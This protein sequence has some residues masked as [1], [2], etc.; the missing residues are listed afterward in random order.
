MAALEP[1]LRETF[2]FLCQLN[3]LQA[4]LCT[5]FPPMSVS[6]KHNDMVAVNRK[7]QDL[8]VSFMSTDPE[9]VRFLLANLRC[10][11]ADLEEDS[12][13]V[14]LSSDEFHDSFDVVVRGS[15][16]QRAASYA[17]AQTGRSKLPPTAILEQRLLS[18]IQFI[19]L[20]VRQWVEHYN[21]DEKRSDMDPY[22]L[23]AEYNEHNTLA[24]YMQETSYVAVNAIPPLMDAC[25]PQGIR[26]HALAFRRQ[27]DEKSAALLAQFPIVAF[28]ASVIRCLN[29]V[30]S[31]IFG[32][33]IDPFGGPDFLFDRY[34]RATREATENCFESHPGNW[35]A[36]NK[37]M[38]DVVEA[39]R[40]GPTG[41]Q[42]ES[43]EQDDDDDAA[44]DQR[45]STPGER[46]RHILYPPEVLGLMTA[47]AGDER[48]LR[49]RRVWTAAE[50]KALR[51]GVR[52]FGESNWK[53][54]KI[55]YKK[56]LMHWTPQ[57]IKEKYHAMKRAFQG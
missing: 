6:M 12:P 22:S 16:S 39:Q 43:H 44:V 29:R 36:L 14:R 53:A 45:P 5:I 8:G 46:R 4:A 15:V 21:A 34:C 32:D 28:Q 51:D 23:F 25:S 31:D 11:V 48:H 37:V 33:M 30:E 35:D 20:P 56:E 3:E 38:T 18:S 47:E 19:L 26:D 57:L 54:I 52:R 24:A 7:L 55:H 9:F 41:D 42:Q 17:A 50:K 1:R 27:V 2:S 40:R 49:K 10:T 13:R